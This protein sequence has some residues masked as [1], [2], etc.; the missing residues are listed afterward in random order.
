M[1]CGKYRYESKKAAAK[2]RNRAFARRHKLPD[3]LRIYPC[4]ACKG[5]HLT[6]KP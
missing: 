2:A 3:R 6:H 1:D 5:W 4:P